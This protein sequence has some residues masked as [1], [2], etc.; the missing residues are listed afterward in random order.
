[1]S[2][3]SI[4]DLGFEPDEVDDVE[5]Q[6][7]I[8]AAV[9]KRDADLSAAINT[10]ASVAKVTMLAY[11]IKTSKVPRKIDFLKD[12]TAANNLVTRKEQ[13]AV[14]N[15]AFA[16]SCEF[17]TTNRA[18]AS[19]GKNAKQFILALRGSP[20]MG[21]SWSSL[22]YFKLLLKDKRRPILFESGPNPEL[23]SAYLFTLDQKS[24]KWEA[25]VFIAYSKL[26]ADWLEYSDVDAVID[27]A[28]FPAET[29]PKPSQL[30][31]SNGHIF[32][33]ISP[34]H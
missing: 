19:E 3:K 22:L 24:Q 12:R 10:F 15:T 21:K 33:A 26:P 23:R 11:G 16:I 32:I 20:G 9:W 18:S 31:E 25:F 28:Q 27:P 7:E 30:L 6:P 2:A 29:V 13:R 34:H 4:F 5:V 14:V 1:M 8:D 17:L